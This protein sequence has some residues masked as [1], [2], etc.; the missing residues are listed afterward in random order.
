MNEANEKLKRRTKDFA[1][2][3]VKLAFLL[4]GNSLGRH[5][6]NQLIRSSTSVAANYRAALLGQSKVAFKA[7]ISIVL[8]E[9]NETVFWLEFC[10]DEELFSIKKMELILREA[11]ELSAIFY[12]TRKT[13]ARS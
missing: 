4:P 3:C 1:H 11:R 13:L 7:K 8:E 6:Q 2:R 10:R 9:A 12:S 5:L